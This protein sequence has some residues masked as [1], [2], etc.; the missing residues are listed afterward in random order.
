MTVYFF[1]SFML[2]DLLAVVLRSSW[3]PLTIR[4]QE[5]R[6]DHTSQILKCANLKRSNQKHSNLKYEPKAFEFRKRTP[7]TLSREHKPVV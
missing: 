4:D 6:P 3:D 1:F 7:E 5:S 2:P